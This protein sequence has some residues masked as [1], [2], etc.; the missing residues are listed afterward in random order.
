MGSPG[1]RG[2]A[3]DGLILAARQ[4]FGNRVLGRQGRVGSTP[5]GA[6]S[7]R[8]GLDPGR[9]VGSAGAGAGAGA[10]RDSA[11]QDPAFPGPSLAACSF[12]LVEGSTRVLNRAGRAS[13]AAGCASP[14]VESTSFCICPSARSIADRRQGLPG[15]KLV[16]LPCC[17]FPVLCVALRPGAAFSFLSISSQHSPCQ[18]SVAI[19]NNR[20]EP[21]GGEYDGQCRQQVTRFVPRARGAP[22][23][24][25]RGTVSFFYSRPVPRSPADALFSCRFF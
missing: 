18:R 5:E 20:I 25:A 13:S 9:R 19:K 12:G 16:G 1:R 24:G 21:G 4:R 6:C 8:S 17:P 11:G 3:W 23:A 2:A 10:R 22:R 14:A 15:P 7:K